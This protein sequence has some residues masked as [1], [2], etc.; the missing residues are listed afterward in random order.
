M[1]IDDRGSEMLTPP[2][3]ERLLALGAK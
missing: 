1:W 3:C 2:E